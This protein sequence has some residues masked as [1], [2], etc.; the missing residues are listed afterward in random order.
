[1]VMNSQDCERVSVLLDRSLLEAIDKIRE[2]WGIRSR[3]D[4]IERLLR[5][6]LTPDLNEGQS[7]NPE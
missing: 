4:I 7:S 5:E 2:E 1:M 6:V 3:A